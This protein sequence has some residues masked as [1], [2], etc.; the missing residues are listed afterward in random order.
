MKQD[1]GLNIHDLSVGYKFPILENIN[2]RLLP[3]NIACLIGE[4]GSGKTTFLNTIAGLIKPKNGKIRLGEKNVTDLSVSHRS[5]LIS[6]VSSKIDAFVQ[7]SVYDIVAMGRS[8]YTNIFDNKSVED[9]EL[10]D[11]ALLN[12]NLKNLENKKLFEISD[13]ERQRCMIARAFVQQTPLILLDEPAAFLDYHNRK[14][15]I[16]DLVKLTEVEKKMIIFSS[17]DID[18]VSKK[19][20][21]FWICHKEYRTIYEYD[22]SKD[23]ENKTIFEIVGS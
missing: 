12:F 3:G 5:K 22:M 16:E 1:T 18:L 7:L 21:L 9:K 8:P 17:H 20:Q 14:K 6:Y 23:G 15:L 2:L 19:I 13:G 4:N 11:K 10:I